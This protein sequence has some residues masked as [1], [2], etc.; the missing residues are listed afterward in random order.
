MRGAVDCGRAFHALDTLAA[1][2][3]WATI[4]RTTACSWTGAAFHMRA[5]LRC[6]RCAA[7][8]PH[9]TSTTTTLPT[10]A[11]ATIAAIMV[12]LSQLVS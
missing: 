4:N 1:I 11:L 3:R 8:A 2:W 5:L 6:C 10:T 12:S 9:F 7:T